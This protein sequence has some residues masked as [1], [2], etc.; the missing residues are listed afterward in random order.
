MKIVII[1]AGIAGCAAYLELRKHLPS[2][3]NDHE[4][5]IYEAYDTHEDTTSEQRGEGV[6]HSSTLVVGGGLGIAPNGL[7]VLKRLDTE[8]LRDIVKGGYT[9]SH[10]N[11]KNKDGYL[12]MRMDSQVAGST[13]S[14]DNAP[15]MYQV[16]SS[17]HSLWRCLRTRIPTHHIVNKRVLEVVSRSEGRN[18]VKFADGSPEVEADLVIGA[19]G[20]RSTT[21]RAIFS[22][23]EEDLYRPHYE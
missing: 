6:T 3:E 9:V 19:D 12:L 5:T 2:D 14:R 1:G 20:I 11:M 17:R 22:D 15:P 13:S 23:T 18:L 7:N 10:S 8:L 21:R 16:T 4:I